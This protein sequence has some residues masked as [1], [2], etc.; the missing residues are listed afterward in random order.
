MEGRESSAAEEEERMMKLCRREGR[1]KEE[2]LQRRDLNKRSM[3]G[4]GSFV[5]EE[6]E[7][8]KN[9]C[10]RKDRRKRQTYRRGGWEEEKALLKIL[11]EDK[12]L[13]KMRMGERESSTV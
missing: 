2:T 13:Q 3:G 7:R 6:D 12:T 9:P 8:K 5:G 1:E 10:G 11:Q 4:R